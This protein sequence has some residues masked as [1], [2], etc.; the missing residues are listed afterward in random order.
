MSNESEGIVPLAGT[1]ANSV[2]VSGVLA[3]HR[4]GFV[5]L[6]GG[7]SSP[8][9]AESGSGEIAV[10]RKSRYGAATTTTVFR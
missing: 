10:G 6:W 5:Q 7:I 1:S 3:N 9:C 2:W 4:L 8:L